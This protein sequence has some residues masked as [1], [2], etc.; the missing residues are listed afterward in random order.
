MHTDTL[1]HY[2]IL[3]VLLAYK[4]NH[5]AESAYTSLTDRGIDVNDTD[6]YIQSVQELMAEIS[7]SVRESS[8]VKEVAK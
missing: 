7:A 5:D 3:N 1:D 4:S 6:G 2:F 8:S